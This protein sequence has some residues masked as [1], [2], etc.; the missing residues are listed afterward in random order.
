MNWHRLNC[1]AFHP[2]DWN[3]DVRVIGVISSQGLDVG[4]WGQSEL[5][6]LFG[7]GGG[8]KVGKP[9]VDL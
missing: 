4:V 2:V 3:I 8:F 7:N 9:A 5:K 1:H 6:L